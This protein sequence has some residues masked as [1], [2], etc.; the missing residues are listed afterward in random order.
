MICDYYG[1]VYH[2]VVHTPLTQKNRVGKLFWHLRLSK[3]YRIYNLYETKYN[4]T[5]MIV[6]AVIT[7]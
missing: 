6:Y 4:N 3:F 7:K 2:S 5:E 1:I